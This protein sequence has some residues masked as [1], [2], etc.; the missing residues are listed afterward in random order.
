MATFR[1]GFG[2]AGS[3]T[4]NTL[5]VCTRRC[6]PSSTKRAARRRP[7]A[8]QSFNTRVSHPLRRT[9]SVRLILMSVALMCASCVPPSAVQL[10][11][12]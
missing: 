9:S 4:T 6:I 2:P 10:D 5:D 11:Y 8:D 12:A 7:A 3:V 1:S